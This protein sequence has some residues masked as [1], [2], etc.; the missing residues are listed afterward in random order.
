VRQ[1]VDRYVKF[2]VSFVAIFY[3]L[4]Q[5]FIRKV[6]RRGAHAEILSGAVYGVCAVADG[7]GHFFKVSS[8]S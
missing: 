3:R 7:K 4:Y 1:N 2:Y 6:L 8:R 5:F